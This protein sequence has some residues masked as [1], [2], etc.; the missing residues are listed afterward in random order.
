MEQLKTEFEKQ[1]EYLYLEQRRQ[2]RG[3]NEKQKY[4]SDNESLL[5]A[6]KESYRNGVSE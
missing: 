3:G 2:Q 6:L 5:Q 1:P 4:Y